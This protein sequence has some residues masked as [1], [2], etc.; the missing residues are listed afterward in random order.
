MPVR[1]KSVRLASFL[2]LIGVLGLGCGDDGGSSGGS[3]GGGSTPLQWIPPGGSSGGG[4]GGSTPLLWNPPGSGGTGTLPGYDSTV[5]PLQTYTNPTVYILGNTHP[6]LLETDSFRKIPEDNLTTMLS[7]WRYNEYVRLTGN[8]PAA[9]ARLVDHT[10]L[11]QLARA[12]CYHYA[13]FHPNNNPPLPA[14]NAEGD[15]LAVWDAQGNL[16]D[17]RIW[18]V[19][20]DVPRNGAA[21]ILLSNI[22]FATPQDVF[23]FVTANAAGGGPGVLAQI[24]LDPN[25]THMSIGYWREPN[26]SGTY[27]WDIVFATDPQTQTTTTWP[28][29]FPPIT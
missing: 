19:G 5:T 7:D 10:Q 16:I 29:W 11:R 4:G 17:G 1:G 9:N 8:P 25:W 23:A 27:Y 12:H 2:V 15:P 13:R 3:S 24:V 18:K 20:L 21:E 6:L 28:P 26:T 22:S 14:I